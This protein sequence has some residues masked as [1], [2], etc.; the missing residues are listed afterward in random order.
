MVSVLR[1]SQLPGWLSN[2][3]AFTRATLVFLAF[4]AVVCS[5]LVICSVNCDYV[6]C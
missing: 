3:V 5:A 1:F 4:C 6:E 2:L